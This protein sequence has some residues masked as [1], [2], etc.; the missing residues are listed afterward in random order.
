MRAQRIAERHETERTG[1]PPQRGLLD[2]DL[3][4]LC[5]PRFR[6]IT[7]SR[8]KVVLMLQPHS[9]LTLLQ[10]LDGTHPQARGPHLPLRP[11]SDGYFVNSSGR[12]SAFRTREYAL[13]P[14]SALPLLY[15][16]RY[17]FGI[18]PL[19]LQI[20]LQGSP[21]VPSRYPSAHASRQCVRASCGF[22]RRS[23]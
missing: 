4:S 13:P 21:F 22:S 12:L 7:K 17:P 14:S 20:G 10:P 1:R 6:G 2:A 8:W 18:L 15:P 3:G 16:H 9:R 19:C 23:L 11:P 5:L